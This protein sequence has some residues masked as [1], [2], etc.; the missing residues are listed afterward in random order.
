MAANSTASANS[1]VALALAMR[2]CSV[3]S[4][5]STTISHV[6]LPLPVVTA[7]TNAF[8]YTFALAQLIKPRP[9]IVASVL[10]SQMQFYR[11]YK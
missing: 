8:R 1:T 9:A 6:P 4:L 11:A 7:S 5:F 10:A 3:L 2:C